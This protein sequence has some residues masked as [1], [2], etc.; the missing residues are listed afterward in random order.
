METWIRLPLMLRI[1]IIAAVWF[2][3]AVL[4]L[5]LNSLDDSSRSAKLIWTA[6]LVWVAVTV[7][8]E[9]GLRPKFGSLEQRVAYKQALRSGELPVGIEL[10]VWRRWLDRSLLTNLSLLC[11]LPFAAFGL[12]SSAGR[13]RTGVDLVQPNRRAK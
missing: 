6:C 7:V 3:Y 13:P 12:A 9:I 8:A 10:D 11:A 4:V 1:L 2:G 5:D